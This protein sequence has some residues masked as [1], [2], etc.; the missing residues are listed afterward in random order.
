MVKRDIVFGFIIGA[1]VGVLVQP[2]ISNFAVTLSNIGLGVN[3]KTRILAFVFFT[4]LAPAALFAASFVGKF[5]APIYQFA[6]F[7]AVGTLN[8]FIN[9]GVGN[10]LA[11]ITNITSGWQVTLFSVVSSL[12]ATTNSFFWNKLWTFDSKG[13]NVSVQAVKFYL[14]TGV[15]IVLNAAAVTLVNSLRPGALDGK[16]WLNV[17]FLSGIAASFLWNFLGYKFIVFK[18]APE[19]VAP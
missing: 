8:S 13:G 14:I 17:A 18:K 6:K 4:L 3:I 15:G 1:A 11:A 7:A 12:V 5:V 19:V 10:A 9:L 2:V 16:V